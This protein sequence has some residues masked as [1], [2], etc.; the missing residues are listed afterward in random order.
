MTKNL[1][2]ISGLL[3]TSDLWLDQIGEFEEDYDLMLF[4]HASHD[5]IP[6]MVGAFLQ[7]APEKFNLAGLSLG[8][9]IALEVMRQ[10]GERV[11]KL[12]LLDTNARA[13][14]EPQIEVRRAAITQAETD[15]VQAFCKEITQHLIHPDRM[16]DKD[17]GERILDMAEDIG[18]EGFKNQQLAMIS[19]PDFRDFLP[20]ITCPTLI[21]CGQQD[22]M[23]PPK[24]HQEM[25]D[26]IP[27]SQFNLI[28]NCGHLS[29]MEQPLMVS[30]LMRMFLDG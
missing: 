29:T 24:V 18:L 5:T 6:A 14:R 23:T 4:D 11:E 10:A 25:A 8:G 12:I 13:D 3:C 20:E 21:I 15:G 30:R 17:L 22:V 9:Y 7:D 2:L 26:L 28:D 19:R 1:V 16:A 27:G